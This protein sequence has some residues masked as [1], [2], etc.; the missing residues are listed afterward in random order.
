MQIHFKSDVFATVAITAAKSPYCVSWAAVNEMNASKEIS[1]KHLKC[2]I[3]TQAKGNFRGDGESN[4]K[5]TGMLVIIFF[6]GV[7]SLRLFRT[8]LQYFFP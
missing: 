1:L 3:T 2:N 7:V 8:E 5:M 4:V 6:S